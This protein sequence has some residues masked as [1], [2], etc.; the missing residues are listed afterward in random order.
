MA[1]THPHTHH[2]HA[3]HTAKHQ[4]YN[5]AFKAGIALNLG[6]LIIEAIYGYAVH[7]VGLISDA[8]HNLTDV[9]GMLLSWG[10]FT[11]A[12]RKSGDKFTYGFGRATILAAFFNGLLLMIAVGVIGWEAY[13]RIL[14]PVKVGGLQVVFVAGVGIIINTAS[15]FF[16]HKDSK[17]DVNMR[18]TYL[19][20]M[21]DALVSAGV[22]VSGLI[23]YFTGLQWPD[24][25]VSVVVLVIIVFSTISLLKESLLQLLD[26]APIHIDVKKVGSSLTNQA[27]VIAY[28]DLHIWNLS[29][30][31][32]ALTVH[33]V[34]DEQLESNTILDTI[35]DMLKEEYH[36]EHST[37]QIEF[38][39]N[40][41]CH[42]ACD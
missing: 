17:H 38:G 29:S 23:I 33:L 2:S 22:V 36:I 39:T 20:M 30:D 18:S 10:A 12:T 6:Y 4:Q 3:S 25:L 37:I 11:L 28:H 9:M 41:H 1:H 16:F 42:Q 40:I 24:P 26:S 35:N 8:L 27:G 34:I 31:V 5:F 15:A 19:H 32:T 14:N 13:H 21:A 7:S